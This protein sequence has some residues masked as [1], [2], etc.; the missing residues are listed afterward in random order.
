V[1]PGDYICPS[2]QYVTG[3]HVDTAGAVNLDCAS[4]LGN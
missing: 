3:I 1:I 4:L 2:G